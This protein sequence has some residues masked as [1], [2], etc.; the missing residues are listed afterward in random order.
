MARC[1]VERLM[2]ELGIAGALRGKR[3]ITTVPDTSD[4]DHGGGLRPRQTVRRTESGRAAAHDQYAFQRA[5]H[6]ARR[7]TTG[8]PS[9]FIHTRSVT[10]PTPA[11]RDS[12]E[13]VA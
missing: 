2:R 12:F 9:G 7:S 8:V 11:W 5:A 4:D 6:S 13:V 3:V 10:A 1:T